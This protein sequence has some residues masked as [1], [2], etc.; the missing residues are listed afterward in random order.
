MPDSSSLALLRM[1]MWRWDSYSLKLVVSQGN[2]RARVTTLRM[3]K[4]GD[5]WSPLHRVARCYLAFAVVVR[6]VEDDELPV[7][8]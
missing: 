4:A 6:T 2:S 8:K 5:Q 1:T 3:T 7:G